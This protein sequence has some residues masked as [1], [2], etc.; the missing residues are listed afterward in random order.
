[1]VALSRRAPTRAGA[2]N[3]PVALRFL[4]RVT[5]QSLLAIYGFARLADDLGDEAPGDRSTLLDW[6][7]AELDRAIGGTATDPVLVRL[8]PTIR[9]HG[10]T[11]EPFRRLIEANRRDQ[12][13]TRYERWPDLA[14][15]CS[16]SADPVGRL[17]LDVFGV[18]SPERVAW[19][20]DVCTALQL[21]EHLQ[22]VGE[23]AGRGR[24]YLPIEDLERFGADPSVIHA[25]SASTELRAV[26]AFECERARA[27]LDSGL[28]LAA[29]LRARGEGRARVAIAGF[30][31]GGLAAIHAIERA[32]HDVLAHRCRTTRRRVMLEMLQLL[33]RAREQGS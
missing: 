12:V 19:S 27:L 10:L 22:D 3:F 2:E 9:D 1:V 14:E 8:T 33:R 24:C 6:L 30:A 5:R 21:V 15:Y 28:A 17:V 18:S 13:T 29:S 16:Y 11:A 25:A 20:D 26:V 23:D 7:D 31:A 4:P 32:D